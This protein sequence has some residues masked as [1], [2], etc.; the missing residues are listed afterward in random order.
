MPLLT[1][2][3]NLFCPD[4]T[5][6]PRLRHW[7]RPVLNPARTAGKGFS[8]EAARISFLYLNIF[9]I[10]VCNIPSKFRSSY[11]FDSR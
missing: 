7:G 8:H 11:L 6:M 1:E 9:Q 5:K 4:S 2:L 3:E 10:V